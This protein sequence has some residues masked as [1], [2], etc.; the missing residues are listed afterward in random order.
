MLGR[1]PEVR[2]LSLATPPVHP[3][4]GRVLSRAPH[5][6]PLPRNQ[7]QLGGGTGDRKVDRGIGRRSCVALGYTVWIM[8]SPLKAR[9]SSVIGGSP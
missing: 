9:S 1:Y 5:L 7:V 3:F 2:F 6:V 8:F 4:Q